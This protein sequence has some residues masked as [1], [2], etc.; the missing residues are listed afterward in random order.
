LTQRGADGFEILDPGACRAVL[1]TVRLGR[2]AVSH[3]APPIILPVAFVAVES[4]VA[5]DA[6][7]EI[8]RRAA[9]A[10]SPSW[11]RP[12]C[13]LAERGDPVGPPFDPASGR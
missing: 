10:G 11:P 7:S 13:G 8:V 6:S 5:I 4:G 3:H 9:D 12:R 1:D 2:V